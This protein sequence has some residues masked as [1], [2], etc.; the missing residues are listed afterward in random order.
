M[1]FYICISTQV[2][3]SIDKFEHNLST[4]YGIVSG[5]KLTYGSENEI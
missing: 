2:I 4:K 5:Y 3:S 1:I